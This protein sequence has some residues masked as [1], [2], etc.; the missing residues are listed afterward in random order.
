MKTAIPMI[1]VVALAS[2]ASAA[3]PANNPQDLVNLETAWSKAMVA[4]DAAALNRIIAPDWTG[5]SP[6]GKLIDRAAVIKETLN[7]PEKLVSMANHD[8]HVRF[9]GPDHAIV[10]GMDNESG[11]TKGKKVNEVYSWT[12]IFAKR[13]G[14]WVAIASQNTPVK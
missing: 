12:D 1:L 2:A 6:Q 5:H 9:V 14:H 4:H 10:Q 11:V 8:V 3:P 13:D 7:G